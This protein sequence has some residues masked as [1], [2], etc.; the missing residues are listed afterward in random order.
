MP[1]VA[2]NDPTALDHGLPSHLEFMIDP[3]GVSGGIYSTPAY[4]TTPATMTNADD[5]PVRSDSRAATAAPSRSHQ[6]AGLVD[7]NYIPDERPARG[8]HQSGK[9]IVRV[10]GLINTTGVLNPIYAGIN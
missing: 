7:I 5:R 6:G 10:Q 2:S 4:T 9:V 3:G 8:S 1:G